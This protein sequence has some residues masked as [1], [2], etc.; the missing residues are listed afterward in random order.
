MKR[1]KIK[2][3]EE[4]DWISGGEVVSRAPEEFPPL[5]GGGGGGTTL[6]KLFSYSNQGGSVPGGK[7]NDTRLSSNF[8]FDAFPYGSGVRNTLERHI[9]HRRLN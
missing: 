6:P 7:R 2:E 5:G 4:E 8:D 1:V 3:E 9:M